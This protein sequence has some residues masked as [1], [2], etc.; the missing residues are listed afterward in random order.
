MQQINTLIFDLGGVIINLDV[1][2]T[3]EKL[4]QLSGFSQHKVI[5]LYQNNENFKLYE[6]GLISDNEFRS[7]VRGLVNAEV[8]DNI[9][10]E[11]WN[12][13]VLDIP[14]ERLI[15]LRAL[16]KNYD[17]YLLSNTN[18][19]H[20][21]RVNEN[22][23][24]LEAES[25]DDYFQKAY[26]S[27]HI[28]MRKPDQEIFKFVVD[29]HNLDPSKTLFL[30]DNESNIAGANKVGIQTLHVSHPDIWRQQLLDG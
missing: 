29:T 13:M 21:Q 4:S 9:I 6:K 8:D 26:Y 17:L 24:P 15:D 28:G 5:E 20:L 23:S 30:D 18:N 2:R 19:I 14:K 27:H 16:S 22:F 1:S 11:A 25:L 12:A 3:I 10:D 7:F